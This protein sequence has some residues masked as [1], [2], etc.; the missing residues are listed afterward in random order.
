[1]PKKRITLIVIPSTDGQV[2]EYRISLWVPWLSG[3]T[4]AAFLFAF[5]YFTLGYHQRENQ[6]RSLEQLRAE[7]D[8]L[9]RSFQL[10]K[11]RVAVL[12]D[13]MTEL[14]EVDEKLRSWHE[15][16]PLT[17]DERQLGVGGPKVLS[18]AI[19]LAVPAHKRR[20]LELLNVRIERLQR[21]VKFQEESFDRI[22]Q[23]FLASGDSLRHMPTILPFREGRAWKTSD[24]GRRVDPFTGRKAY[25]LGIDFAGR[26]GTPIFAT[27]D[28][29]VSHAYNDKRLGNVVVIEHDIEGKD[30]DGN[31]Y[32]KE[33]I[34]RTEYG[35]MESMLVGVDDRVKRHQ[36]IG[37]MG[38]TGRSTGPHLHYAVRYQDRSR[39]KYKGYEDPQKF[40]LDF[41]DKQV[42]GWL[43]T[44]E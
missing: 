28:G 32:M 24:F 43:G 41:H 37:A 36:M 21:E 18:D 23:K 6:E 39:G 19:F 2:R 12:D 9:I 17:F 3:L 5:G 4:C 10:T 1:M 27:A 22:T 35:H 33:G 34:Y 38:N 20:S 30:D 42:A 25:H 40:L 8:E 14:V 29:I 7:N 16:E 44:D 15:M 26:K 13:A 31:K 11:K